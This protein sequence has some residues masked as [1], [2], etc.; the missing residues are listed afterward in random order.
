MANTTRKSTKT[1]W[2]FPGKVWILVLFFPFFLFYYLIK[3][4]V[5]YSR[6][7]SDSARC[8]RRCLNEVDK[9]NGREFEVFLSR[10]Y[11][12]LGYSV[13]LTRASRDYGADLILENR[14]QRTA[15]QAKLLS[16]GA[17]SNKAVSEVYA[18]KNYYSASDA[19]VITNCT[20]TA[21]AKKLA[22]DNNVTLIDRVGLT[23]LIGEY[24]RNNR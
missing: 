8:M 2:D 1:G 24:Q 19:L 17:V 12:S 20:Y 7:M 10:M 23:R 16:A 22:Q 18:S 9:M 14:G 13:T 3:W 5:R 15:V 6:G 4:I 21:A 11:G